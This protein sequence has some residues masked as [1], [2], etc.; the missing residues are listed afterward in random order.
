MLTQCEII[1]TESAATLWSED[2]TKRL[3]RVLDLIVYGNH[4]HGSV[5]TKVLLEVR[6]AKIWHDL[7]DDF[8]RLS[9]EANGQKIVIRYYKV[10]SV[11]LNGVDAW[12]GT[13]YS[14]LP[15]LATDVRNL[16]S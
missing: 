13:V 8:H 1:K 9:F 12:V 5:P 2:R 14:L 7:S 15:D 11:Q 4:F 6:N 10:F 3:H 16:L